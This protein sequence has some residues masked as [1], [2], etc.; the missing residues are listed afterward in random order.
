MTQP[1]TNCVQATPARSM[2]VAEDWCSV[3]G[4]I[5]F[6]RSDE[7]WVAATLTHRLTSCRIPERVCA[8]LFLARVP[9][10]WNDSDCG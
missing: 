6:E 10:A 5:F 1:S 7:T 3:W 2:W 4:L 8:E 9:E